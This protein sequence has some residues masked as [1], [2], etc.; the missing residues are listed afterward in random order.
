VDKPLPGR[1]TKVRTYVRRFAGGLMILGFVGWFFA[2]PLALGLSRFL[3]PTFELPLGDVPSIAV[4][5]TGLIY[6]AAAPYARVQVYDGDGAFVRGMYVDAGGGTFA[7]AVGPDGL[8]HAATSR[9]EL[10]YVFDRQGRMVARTLDPEYYGRITRSKSP[11]Y[12]RAGNRYEIW[13]GVLW[14]RVLRISPSG[15]RQTVVTTP[16]LLWF[17]MAPLPA[18][19]FAAVGMILLDLTDPSRKARRRRDRMNTHAH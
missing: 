2:L 6:C 17:V 9:T 11:V 3:A 5:D 10:H 19:L 12:D 15:H 14:P 1:N 4:D 13:P 16:I 18:W 7:V 8:I